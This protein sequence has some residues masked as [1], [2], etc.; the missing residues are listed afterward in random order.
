MYNYLKIIYDRWLCG[1]TQDELDEWK[2][3]NFYGKRFKFIDSYYYKIGQDAMVNP[4][5]EAK[6]IKSSLIN[7]SYSVPSFIQEVLSHNNMIFMCIQN[8]LDM[9]DGKA[10]ADAFKPYPYES[11]SSITPHSDFICMYTY[12]TSHNSGMNKEYENEDN[13]NI[14]D[15]F[16]LSD[17]NT[18]AMK[19]PV[20]ITSKNA[21]NGYSI[22]CFG[23]TFG[24]QYQSYFTDIKVNMDSPVVTEQVVKTQFSLGN[25]AGT[26]KGDK[27]IGQDLFTIY[28][29]N[30]Y[31]C[32]VT[33]LGCGWIQP[34]MY[35]CLNNIPL[36]RGTYMI[37][38]VSHHIEQG[39]F[40]TKFSGNRLSRIATPL[41]KAWCL[42]GDG[43]SADEIEAKK[44]K[45]AS[46]D[47]DCPYAF[48]DPASMLM[49]MGSLKKIFDDVNSAGNVTIMGETHPLNVWLAG[50]TT[51]EM[52]SDNNSLETKTAKALTLIC[53]ANIYNITAKTNRNWPFVLSHLW[54]GE[55]SSPTAPSTW[56]KTPLEYEL[57]M[58]KNE[59]AVA[60]AMKD[61]RVTMRLLQTMNQWRGEGSIR[62]RSGTSLT[63][64]LGS[65]RTQFFNA[66]GKDKIL[67]NNDNNGEDSASKPTKEE[68]KLNKNARGLYRAIKATCQSSDST[69]TFTLSIGKIL[70]E[71]SFTI[72]VSST[73]GSEAVFDAIALTYF[74][75]YDK[76]Y[77]YVSNNDYKTAGPQYIGISVPTVKSGHKTIAFYDNGSIS[78]GVKYSQINSKLQKTL[79]KLKQNKMKESEFN[80]YC[81]MITDHASVKSDITS[82]DSLINPNTGGGGY[83]VPAGDIKPWNGLYNV[84]MEEPLRKESTP[85]GWL[86]TTRIYGQPDEY[87]HGKPHLG[88]DFSYGGK[89]SATVYA[90]ADGKLVF[91]GTNSGKQLNR[92]I[93]V[94]HDKLK[95]P[96][97]KYC[98]FSI[99]MHCHPNISVGSSVNKGQPIGATD[100][101]FG[102]LNTGTGSHCH[103]EILLAPIQS[104]KVNANANTQDPGKFIHGPSQPQSG[105]RR[106]Y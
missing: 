29:N 63:L 56:W 74:D 68:G 26:P 90:V 69:S 32:S 40:T 102:P 76:L 28:S 95:D 33:S 37:F 79:F 38:K 84:S 14:G 99:Y 106:Y 1:K 50:V 104:E 87:Q 73:K 94:R 20:A 16:L 70:T 5:D 47:N 67:W 80:V 43:Q 10:I 7:E 72:K 30:S 42:A 97:G 88:I 65:L 61:K 105:H 41:V 85:N 81:L 71:T 54:K 77:W 93:V 75:F 53:I 11:V 103:F 58:V 21:S 45:M 48:N 24:K 12:E 8:F 39:K 46:P 25:M 66:D 27:Y 55:G 101:P 3:E 22:P 49:G 96:T 4:L 36:F 64:Q 2:L 19:A 59:S 57:T 44:H 9:S 23:V 91:Y 51:H 6:R 13:K 82:C 78:K 18:I 17:D 89:G 52:G 62:E 34:T 15:S 83:Y 92:Y 35:F 60:E 98:V 31:T 100:Y 86:G